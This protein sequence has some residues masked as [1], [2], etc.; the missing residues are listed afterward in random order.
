MSLSVSIMAHPDRRAQVR[1][2]QER[3]IVSAPVGW[4]NEGNAG[5]DPDRIWRTARRAWELY[6]PA[7]AWHLLLQDD[8]VIPVGFLAAACRALDH[9][10]CPSVVSFYTGSGRPLSPQWDRVAARADAAGA[11]WIIGPRVMWGVALAVPTHLIPEMLAACDRFYAVPDDMRV[12]RWMKR[13]RLEA[14]FSW[15]SL[16]NHPD[17]GSLT[18][19]GSGRTARNYVGPD[20]RSATWEG[21][22]VRWDRP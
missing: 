3:L 10:R 6:N 13:S 22:V 2:L 5:R 7:A 8:A 19:H 11:S 17:E 20:A 4:D 18:G 14:W 21:P 1:A 12:G 15:P 16:V 9:V